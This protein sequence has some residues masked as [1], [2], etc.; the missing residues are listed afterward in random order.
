MPSELTGAGR[1]PRLS[2]PVITYQAVDT[3][4]ATSK[5]AVQMDREFKELSRAEQREVLIDLVRQGKS[6][7]EIGTAFELSQWQVRNLRYRL[8]LKKD[9]GGNLYVEP[10][11]GTTQVPAGPEAVPGM[12]VAVH[13]DGLVLSIRGDY[14][15]VELSRRL[16]ALR[17]LIMSDSAEK[18]YEI[19]LELVEYLEV[20]DERE[21]PQEV[22]AADN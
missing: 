12:Q 22:G 8:G 1:K 13:Q 19:A 17:A 3:S 4:S 18:R 14:Q 10:P 20:E 16:E 5:E 21:E 15:A 2:G 11:L 7:E 6:D 9:R